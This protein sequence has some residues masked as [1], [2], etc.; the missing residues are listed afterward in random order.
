MAVAVKNGYIEEGIIAYVFREQAPATV[1]FY[2][3]FNNAIK[4]HFY[5]TSW[6][7]AQSA[8]A[9]NGYIYEGIAAWVYENPIPGSVPFYRMYS[10]NTKD[11]VYTIS[12][13]PVNNYN[14]EGVAAYVLTHPT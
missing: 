5:T 11:H 4:H 14:L 12:A 3:M 9:N 7:E 8:N 2:R 10:P 6:P 1:A 13:T